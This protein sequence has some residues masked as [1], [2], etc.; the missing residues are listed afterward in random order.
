MTLAVSYLRV[1]GDSQILG[2]G[3][4]RQREIILKYASTH[5][6]EIVQE[7]AEEG[8]TG[9][10]ELEGRAALS[11][12]LQYIREHGITLVVVESSDRLARDM[13]VAEVLIREFQKINVR[14]ISA[15]GGIDLTAGDDSNPTA[16]L[17]RQ[18][19]AAVAE[20][21]RCV[22]NLKLRG[23]RQRIKENGRHPGQ[24]NYSPDEILN[25]NSEGRKPFGQKTGEAEV[26]DRM[27]K[28]REVENMRYEDIAAVLNNEGVPCR[29]AHKGKVWKAPVIKRILDRKPTTTQEGEA[30]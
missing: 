24:K 26:L 19:L 10:M 9:K 22:I 14:V 4:P 28:M 20:F 18:I 27:R 6:I 5:D 25:R 3:F 17:I 7:F 30:A 21:D 13:I 16:K 2:D 8:V 23:A 15:A 11:A 29:M 12:C 1:S